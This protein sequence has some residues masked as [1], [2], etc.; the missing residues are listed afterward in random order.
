MPAHL[1]P[2]LRWAVARV[3]HVATL[4]DSSPRFVR[5]TSPPTPTQSPRCSFVNSSKSDVTASSAKSWISPLES[6]IVAKAS[7]PWRR[8]SIRRPATITQVQFR[9]L[10]EVRRHRVEREELDLPARVAHRGE[11]QFALAAQEHQASRDHHRVARLLAVGE[12][13]VAALERRGER[14]MSK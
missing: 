1:S 6:R 5:T 2:K 13:V 11:G 14:V 10:F 4:T 9:E 3:T 7:L 12:V 8:R